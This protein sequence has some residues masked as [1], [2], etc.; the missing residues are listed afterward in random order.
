MSAHIAAYGRLGADPRPI[1]TRTGNP[2][3]AARMA[4]DIPPS[5]RDDERGEGTVWLAVIAFGHQAEDL[6]RHSKGDLV[7]VAGEMRI[8]RFESRGEARES[9]QVLAASVVSARTVRP[10]G[11][12]R[13]GAPAAQR[14]LAGRAAPNASGAG[15]PAEDFDDAIP[16]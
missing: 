3:T 8:S 6:A 15:K 10:G 1:E 11:G 13:K 4:V 5:Q 9:W 12:R 7:S 2:M 16:F 14:T